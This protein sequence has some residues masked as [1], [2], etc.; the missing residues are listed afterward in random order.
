VTASCLRVLLV[1]DHAV[2]RAG[3]R[4]LLENHAGY[5]VVGEA[6]SRAEAL[7]Q[8]A[9][10]R[11]DVVLLDLDL[12]GDNALDFLKELQDAVG[13]ARI[14]ILTGIRDPEMHRRAIRLGA[15]GIVMKEHAAESLLKSI[16]KVHEGEL[17]VDRA[18]TAEI[19]T[20]MVSAG[21]K[22]A[23][24]PNQ[25][26]IATLTVREREVT[27]LV[28][29]GLKNKEIADRLF[30]SDITVRHHLTSIFSKLDVQD[31]LALVLHAFRHGLAEPPK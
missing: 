13:S 11:P 2:V 8:A 25:D 30:V 10:T 9:G 18:L 5:A 27:A 14:L 22:P 1:D 7:A 23:R 29:Q 20:E 31:R 16:R 3:L 6:G 28:A 26:R 4:L 17:W 15:R 12:G 21:G 19:L 24:D